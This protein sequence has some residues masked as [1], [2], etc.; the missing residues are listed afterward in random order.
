MAAHELM[1]YVRHGIQWILSWSLEAELEFLIDKCDGKSEAVD[2][3]F[4]LGEISGP[5]QVGFFDLAPNISNRI[6]LDPV[7]DGWEASILRNGEAE[8]RDQKINQKSMIDNGFEVQSQ[9]KDWR[10]LHKV[11]ESKPA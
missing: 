10:Q 8:L 6:P 11:G 2:L 5:V 4:D 7:A 3:A 9:T 1:P